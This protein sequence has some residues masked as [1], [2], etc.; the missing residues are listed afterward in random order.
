MIRAFLVDDEPLAL[1]RLTRLLEETGRVQIAGT[2]ADPVDALAALG[3]ANP[4]VL[5]LDIQMPGMNGFEMLSMLESQPLVVFTTA[6]DQYALRAFEVNSIDYLLKP[7]ERPQLDRALA[8]LE[9]IRGGREPR[10]DLRAAIEQLAASLRPRYLDRIA[11]RSG[12]RVLF[13]ELSRIT[14]FFA[15]DKLT[16]AATPGKNFVVDHT[17]AELEHKLDPQ[18]FFRIHRASLLNL[19]YLQ[20]IDAWIGGRVLA[21]LKDPKGTELAVARDRVRPLRERLGI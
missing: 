9:R 19:D 16:Y 1:R 18:R 3:P 15:E 13:V 20:E 8:K 14:H 4:D 7:I 11:T 5:F 10:P 2:S 17:I 21:R 12:E 6:F